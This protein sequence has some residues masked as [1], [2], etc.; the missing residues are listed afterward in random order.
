MAVILCNKDN[1]Q[2]HTWPETSSL[3][4]YESN[5]LGA[6]LHFTGE[7]KCSRKH[8]IRVR[9][10]YFIFRVESFDVDLGRG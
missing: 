4:N 7:V 2:I 9:M 8:K 1:H 3:T 5:M 6:L 10:S